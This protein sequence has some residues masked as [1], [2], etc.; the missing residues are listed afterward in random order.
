MRD[1]DRALIERFLRRVH[2]FR[3]LPEDHL[4]EVTED[5]DILSVKGGETVLSQADESTDLYMVLRGG[6]RVTFLDEEGN[7]LIL[8][9]FNEGDFFGE[10]SLIDG[11]P[12]SAT[13]VAE[14][15]VILGVLKRERFL[16][17]IKENPM[18]AIEILGALV[19]RLRKADE[20]IESLAFLDVR[21]RLVRLLVN[22]AEREGERGEDGYYRIRKQ[23]HKE[24]A[25]RIGASREAITKALKALAEDQAV[26]E[27]GGYFLISPDTF[28]RGG[29]SF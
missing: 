9:N 26:V 18:I 1:R 17:A 2:I 13:V 28:A 24:L 10:M 22:T 25:V 3:G 12:R 4:R 29:R 7:E 14:G 19:E 16:E 11:K 8:T 21:E 15:D 6:V 20:M 23:T 5:F 27:R